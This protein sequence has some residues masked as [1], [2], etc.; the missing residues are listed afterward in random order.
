LT[1]IPAEPFAQPPDRHAA[2]SGLNVAH[3]DKAQENLPAQ[4]RPAS[5]RPALEGDLRLVRKR[6]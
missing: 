2:L 1:L 6:S 4:R 5:P 3:I